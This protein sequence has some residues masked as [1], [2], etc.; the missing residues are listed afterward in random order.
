[1]WVRSRYL[2]WKQIAQSTFG[3]T[4]TDF[5]CFG[6]CFDLRLT[7]HCHFT[8]LVGHM[9]VLSFGYL[10]IKVLVVT[11]DRALLIRNS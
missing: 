1:M 2:V 9:I 10:L 3:N 4:L 8:I 6:N 11:R 5:N 7:F